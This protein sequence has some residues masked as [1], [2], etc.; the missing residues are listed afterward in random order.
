MMHYLNL[1][2]KLLTYKNKFNSFLKIEKQL[3]KR[4]GTLSDVNAVKMLIRC[5]NLYKQNMMP[6]FSD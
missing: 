1:K 2:L 4:R 3:W 6:N 5:A